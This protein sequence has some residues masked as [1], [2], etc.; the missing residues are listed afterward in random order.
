YLAHNLRA[1]A[2]TTQDFRSIWLITCEATTTQN[3]RSI[4]LITC[5]VPEG[6]L[7]K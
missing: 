6:T 1:K 4:W 3:F 7:S 2:T 5:E